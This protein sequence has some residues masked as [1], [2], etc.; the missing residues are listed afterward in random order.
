MRVHRGAHLTRHRT[1]DALALP[2]IRGA[3]WRRTTRAGDCVRRASMPADASC[4]R[5][6]AANGRR[7]RRTR[8][9]GADAV[10]AIGARA[11]VTPRPR[12]GDPPAA[13]PTAR[14]TA[15]RFAH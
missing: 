15:V 9:E 4:A 5:P 14:A 11:G 3:E 1:R 13:T 8:A 12:A 7:S 6:P 10:T 2:A